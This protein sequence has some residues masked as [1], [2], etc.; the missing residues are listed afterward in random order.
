MMTPQSLRAP[1][2]PPPKGYRTSQQWAKLWGLSQSRALQILGAAVRAKRAR[3]ILHPRLDGTG[4]ARNC[5]Y[6]AEL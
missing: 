1:V 6:Y 3:R 4:G 5:G 2:P